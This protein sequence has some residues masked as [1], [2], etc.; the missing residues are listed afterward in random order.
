MGRPLRAGVTMGDLQR[1]FPLAPVLRPENR[2]RSCAS[3]AR[4]GCPQTRIVRV[5]VCDRA[6]SLT[7]SVPSH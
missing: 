1:H 5:D 6:L 3:G 2:G 7:M 4:I